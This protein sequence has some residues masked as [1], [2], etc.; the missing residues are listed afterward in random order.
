MKLLVLG[1][2]VLKL[3]VLEPPTMRCSHACR[4]LTP[5]ILNSVALDLGL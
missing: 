4:A 3:L 2:L 1:L 5:I